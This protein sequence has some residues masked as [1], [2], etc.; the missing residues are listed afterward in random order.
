MQPEIELLIGGQTE[1][2][3][4]ESQLIWAKKDE[5]LSIYLGTKY[6]GCMDLVGSILIKYPKNSTLIIEKSN[7]KDLDYL[8]SV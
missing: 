2:V 4:L 5:I 8:L 6:I 7:L 1:E 3:N